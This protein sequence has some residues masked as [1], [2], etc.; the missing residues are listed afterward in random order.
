VYV[1]APPEKA[2]SLDRFFADVD[3][4][5]A[6]ADPRLLGD[7][8]VPGTATLEMLAHIYGFTIDPDHRTV[9]L[10]EEF[11]ARLGPRVQ[12]GAAVPIG[13]IV[14]I[15]HKVAAGRVVQ[16]ALQLTAPDP[17]PARLNPIGALKALGRRLRSALTTL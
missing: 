2:R 3:A 17:A 6:A 15:A 7:F 14:M 13:P 10:A 1:L 12:R 16:V 5:P 9:S 11:V 8:Y 4:S